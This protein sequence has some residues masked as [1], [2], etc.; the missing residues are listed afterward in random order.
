MDK[1]RAVIR[2]LE[3]AEW[4]KWSDREIARRCAVDSTFVSR[5]HRELSE[6][7]PQI[8]TPTPR[9]VERNGTVYQMDTTNIGNKA[10]CGVAASNHEDRYKPE[11]LPFAGRPGPG[12]LRTASRADSEYMAHCPAYETGRIPA[13]RRRDF[14]VLWGSPSA[15]AISRAV[16]P[17]MQA[18]YRISNQIAIKAIPIELLLTLFK[19]YRFN[20]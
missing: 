16:N 7:K 2:M 9:L 20:Y 19:K 17:F 14:I 13:A 3:D 8:D 5:L 15:S 1:R 12:L 18:V 11:S 10:R 4:S 6:V